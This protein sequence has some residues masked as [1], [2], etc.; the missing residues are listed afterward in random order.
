M[1][2]HRKFSLYISNHYHVNLYKY[3]KFN[4]N[5]DI[6]QYCTGWVTL[7]TL[8][9]AFS[10]NFFFPNSCHEHNFCGRLN[11]F[12]TVG[13]DK[14]FHNM[15]ISRFCSKSQYLWQTTL[16]N[17]IFRSCKGE[18]KKWNSAAVSLLSAVQTP[19]LNMCLASLYSPKRDDGAHL[20]MDGNNKKD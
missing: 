15:Q 10:A 12:P 16:L 20:G 11:F 17:V 3:Q 7:N 9:S 18:F 5:E 1:A 19:M 13:N 14:L 6:T 2:E 8:Q 4:E